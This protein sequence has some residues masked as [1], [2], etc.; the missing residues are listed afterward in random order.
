MASKRNRTIVL[1]KACLHMIVKQGTT[2]PVADQDRKGQLGLAEE[3]PELRDL[4]PG[5][6][7]AQ[8]RDVTVSNKR[9]FLPASAP[10]AN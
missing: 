4:H 7:G 1:G 5:D 2:Q 9:Y 3:C 8:N 10:D 6:V